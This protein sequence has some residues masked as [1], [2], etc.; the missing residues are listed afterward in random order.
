MRILAAPP[1]YSR[2]TEQMA[3]AVLTAVTDLAA[4]DAK[5]GLPRGGPVTFVA[6]FSPNDCIVDVEREVRRAMV[7]LVHAVGHLRRA[8]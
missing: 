2:E 3:E 8:S 7:E 1:G 4:I 5:L 6:V